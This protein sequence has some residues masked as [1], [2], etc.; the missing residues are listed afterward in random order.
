MQCL[1]VV[2]EIERLSLSKSD[3][4]HTNITDKLTQWLCPPGF[5]WHLTFDTPDKR[6]Q[7]IE[8]A[9]NATEIL[10]MR[11]RREA[12]ARDMVQQK[13]D[14]STKSMFPIFK[15]DIKREYQILIK[16]RRSLFC[17]E[18]GDRVSAEMD[19]IK[20]LKQASMNSGI[21][22][23]ERRLFDKLLKARLNAVVEAAASAASPKKQ[24]QKRTLCSYCH[25][26][27]PGGAAKCRKKKADAVADR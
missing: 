18:L 14:T 26:R 9:K 21:G 3:Q 22:E 25:K 1:S 20:R 11:V 7:A 23:A 8:L 2:N 5:S 16:F 27:H 24:K 15:Y 12:Q 13:P 19:R 17:I 10:N 4:L 6:K